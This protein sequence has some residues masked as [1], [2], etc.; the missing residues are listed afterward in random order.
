MTGNRHVSTPAIQTVVKGREPEIL[1]RLEIG[2]EGGNPHIHCPYPSHGDKNPSWRWDEQKARAFCTCIEKSHSIFDVVMAVKGIEFAAAKVL[3]A[4]LIGREDLIRQ[5][6]G[7][8]DGYQATDA[9]SLLNPAAE[10]RD[11]DLAIKYLA[12]ASVSDRKKCLARPPLSW[13]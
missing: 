3:V 11:D 13:A 6:R 9:D 1:R 8:E 4:Q 5:S 10:H 7:K 2:W 12:Y